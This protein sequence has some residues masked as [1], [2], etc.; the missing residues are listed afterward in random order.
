M[1]D[2]KIFV[3]EIGRLVIEFSDKG[4]TMPKEKVEQ[5]YE[6]L[7]DLKDFQIHQAINHI[8]KTSKFAPTMSEIYSIAKDLTE[9]KG[10]KPIK[11]IQRE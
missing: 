1:I 4:F 8:L 5:W 10:L 7:K 11:I 3:K 9:I 6:L 2:K